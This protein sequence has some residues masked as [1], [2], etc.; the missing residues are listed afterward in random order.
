MLQ[1]GRPRNRTGTGFTPV[2]F[3][4]TASASSARRPRKG[5][6]STPAW[7]G[8]IRAGAGE[9]LRGKPDALAERRVRVDGAADVLGVGAHLDGEADLR[10]QVARVQPDDPPS[11]H[12]PVRLV[13][14]QL[15][16]SFVAAVRDRPSA[17]RPGE[18]RLS[19]FLAA[20]L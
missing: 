16:E 18:D 2:D 17:R 4:S 1:S 9:D 12:A 11:D 6:L 14:E 13:V 7:R 3:E 19:V 10:D 8:K 20:C 15:D 5:L